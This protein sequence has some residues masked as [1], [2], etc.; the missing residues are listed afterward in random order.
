MRGFVLIGWMAIAALPGMSLAATPAAA[1]VPGKG[2]AVVA[3]KAPELTGEQMV[4]RSRQ[5][6]AQIRKV[7]GDVEAKSSAAQESKDSIRANCLGERLRV[8][9]G[10]LKS[11]EAA[12]ADLEKAAG[13]H[14]AEATAREFAKIAGIRQKVDE[15]AGEANECVGKSAGGD[16]QTGVDVVAQPEMEDTAPIRQQTV[17]ARPPA[18]SP[19]R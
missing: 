9:K 4:E 10:L 3:D 8:A 15:V 2:A 16:G 14:D 13:K 17:N 11:G 18:A 7:V 5:S 19:T 6:I 12:L 1:P